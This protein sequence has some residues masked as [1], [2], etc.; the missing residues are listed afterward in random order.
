MTNYLTTWPNETIKKR[1]RLLTVCDKAL[2]GIEVAI[3]YGF[4]GHRDLILLD[5]AITIIQQRLAEA[6]TLLS[7]LVDS[8]DQNDKY[9]LW[10]LDALGLRNNGPPDA[11][12]LM[13][14]NE[15]L[16]AIIKQESNLKWRQAEAPKKWLLQM[17]TN[18]KEIKAHLLGQRWQGKAKPPR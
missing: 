9:P 14:E 6:T 1:D 4:N 8:C 15:Q 18:F 12:T 2:T 13:A 7:I 10:V 11:F 16:L 3:D 5:K 17:Q